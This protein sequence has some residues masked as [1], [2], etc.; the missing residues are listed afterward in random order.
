[1]SEQQMKTVL[2]AC[3]AYLT[4]V[5]CV[6]ITFWLAYLIRDTFRDWKYQNQRD[7]ELIKKG[8]IP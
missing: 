7:A 1:M 3:V 4:I 5:A 6:G 2:M 8:Y